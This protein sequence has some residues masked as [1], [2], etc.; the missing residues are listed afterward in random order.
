M[1]NKTDCAYVPR[2]RRKQYIEN[3]N[4]R[5]LA[6]GGGGKGAATQRGCHSN[7]SQGTNPIDFNQFLKLFT[8]EEEEGEGV[9][10]EGASKDYVPSSK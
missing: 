1:Q 2:P 5:Q 9:E 6:N 4:G 3:V 8:E 10:E 7:F